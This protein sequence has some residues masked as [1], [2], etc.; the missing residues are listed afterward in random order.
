VLDI[1]QWVPGIEE[2]RAYPT[3]ARDVLQATAFGV[4]FGSAPWPRSAG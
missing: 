2:E 1:M 4:R 3:L